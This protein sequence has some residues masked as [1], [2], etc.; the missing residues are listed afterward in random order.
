MASMASLEVASVV[1]GREVADG[2][3]PREARKLWFGDR[4]RASA[5]EGPLSSEGLQVLVGVT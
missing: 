1:G 2:F 4:Q 3:A 5:K